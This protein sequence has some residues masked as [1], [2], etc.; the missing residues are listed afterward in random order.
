MSELRRRVPE[1]CTAVVGE[2]RIFVESA[3]D[4]VAVLR[5]QADPMPGIQ[6]VE[7]LWEEIPGLH[8]DTRT[9]DELLQEGT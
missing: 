5:I 7:G 4:G 2:L 1:K 9:L 6:I 8:T 3:R